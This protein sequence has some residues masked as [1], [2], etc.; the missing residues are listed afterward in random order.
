MQTNATSVDGEWNSGRML[1]ELTRYGREPSQVRSTLASPGLDAL[2]AMLEHADRYGL[3][4]VLVARPI[5]RS[6]P[7]FAGWRPR[8]RS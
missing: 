5:L 2:R 1:P 6:A 8:G 3:K 7:E 4:W